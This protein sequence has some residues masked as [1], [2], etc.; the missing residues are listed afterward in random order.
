MHVLFDAASTILSLAILQAFN[1]AVKGHF[2]SDKMPTGMKLILLAST[3]TGL[4]FLILLWT[5]PQ[6]PAA[7]LTGMAI[8]IGALALFAASLA[9]TKKVRFRMAFDE[10]PPDELLMSGP[11]RY[12]RHPFYTSY[13]VFW[14]GFALITFSWLAVPLLVLITAI[15]SVAARGEEQRFTNSNMAA[16]HALYRQQA[17]MFWPKLRRKGTLPASDAGGESAR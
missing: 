6:P 2:R 11:Y 1:W 14:T 12:I 16:Q 3:V 8:E 5:A 15:Y 9:A 13:L 4:V 10:A 17:G 7:H